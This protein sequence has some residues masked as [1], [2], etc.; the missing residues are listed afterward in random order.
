MTNMKTIFITFFAFLALFQ[1]SLGLDNVADKDGCWDGL[2]I[3]KAKCV[4]ASSKWSQ[5]TKG[6]FIL[7]LTN[8]CDRRVYVK[9]CNQRKNGSWDCGAGGIAGRGKTSWATYDATGRSQWMTVGSIR[10]NKDWVCAGKISNWR[11]FPKN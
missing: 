6:K 11:K 5:H 7:Y 10:S 3:N 8:T 4:K 9:K 2:H 1:C